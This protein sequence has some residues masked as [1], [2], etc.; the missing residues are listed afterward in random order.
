MSQEKI[1]LNQFI[2]SEVGSLFPLYYELYTILYYMRVNYNCR[3]T[4]Q[5]PSP[6]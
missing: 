5:I 3:A 1:I 6:I 4:G 2:K